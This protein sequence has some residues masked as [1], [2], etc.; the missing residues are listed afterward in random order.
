MPILDI[1]P[2][3]F[4]GTKVVIGICGETGGGKT[5][6]A[7]YIARGMVK[8]ASEIGFLDTE[9]KRGTYYANKLDGKFL[10]ADLYPPFS[11]SRYAAAIKEFQDAGVKVLVIDSGSHEWEG[12]GGCEDIAHQKMGK[13]GMDNWIGAKRE[14][15]K[16]MNVLLYSNL[17]VI[18]CLRAREKTD[19]K[20]PDKPVS[21]GI[22]P[23]CEKNFMFEMTASILISSQGKTREFIKVPEFLME[24][25]NSSDEYLGIKAGKKII[26]WVN[27]GER[28]DPE[29][30]KCKS[31][32]LTACEKGE[33]GLLE[34]WKSL[35][36]ALQKK[37]KVHFSVFKESA[38]EYDKQTKEAQET[39]QET[40][41]RET[42]GKSTAPTLL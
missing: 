4:G 35:T 19:F 31:E 5:L 34:L 25:F 38:K 20:V 29:I 39:P 1:K 17:H 7:L 33:A 9:N 2:V 13:S 23:I 14:H 24:A 21:L 16:F 22:K 28:E 8:S 11:P 36:P 40:L 42:G 10:I 12:E 18:V 15:K 32:L 3:S 41:K 30:A 26:E 27:T 6:T 37:M